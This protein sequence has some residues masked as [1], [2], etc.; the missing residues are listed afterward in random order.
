MKTFTQVLQ[1]ELLPSLGCTEPIA[2]AYAAA[3]ARQ[4]LG[5]QAI[6][7][8]AW[9]SGNVVKNVKS[10]VVPNSGGLK[11]IN[12]AAILGLLGGDSENR[13]EVLQS[14]SD[15]QR[16]EAKTLLEAGFCKC[17]FL[18][19]GSALDIVIKA[20]G[21]CHSAVVEVRDFHTNL[22]YLERDGVVSLHIPV[23]SSSLHTDEP[24][25]SLHAILE[26][27]E[28]TELA[29]L[30][31]LLH[32]QV[33]MNEAIAQEGLRNPY[34]AQIGR[35]L[36]KFDGNTVAVR[37]KAYAAAGS[38]ARMGGCPMPVVINSGSGN[39][40]ITVSLPVIQYARE[41]RVSKEKMFK[42]LAVSNLIAIYQKRQI[43]SLSAYCGAV[44]AAC[45]SGAAI[46]YLQGATLPQ[47]EQTIINTIACVGGIF[48]DGAKPSCAAKIAEC[49]DAAILAGRLAIDGHGFN[50][51]EGLVKE[52]ADATIRCIGSVA[53]EGMRETDR[54][55]LQHMLEN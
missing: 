15:Q 43:G 13:L 32:Q 23:E 24:E 35:S 31:S 29:V 53:R 28:T 52:G 18:N 48:C 25:W 42:A 50:S 5:E 55:I 51:G 7:L 39:Q 33:Q 26:Y 14:V 3:K 12:A 40:G 47:I 41:L 44:C 34:G 38:D 45:G 4:L 22:T 11:G 8:E 2:V 19:S 9:C 1:K 6:R 27:A 17:F 49:V 16:E 10:V 21:A 54:R 30:E 46:A 36:L 20:W 37:A